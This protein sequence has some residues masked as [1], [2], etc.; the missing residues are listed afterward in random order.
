MQ[1]TLHGSG[2]GSV[3]REVASN[4]RGPRFKSSH[5]QKFINIEHLYTVNCVL[6]RQKEKEK[7]AGNGTFLKKTLHGINLFL[8][9]FLRRFLLVFVFLFLDDG[10]GG[11]R[12]HSEN[13]TLLQNM[14]L[15]GRISLDFVQST[16]Q[17][18][19]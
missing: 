8:R 9:Q 10:G 17:L 15:F 4:S 13:F 2:C 16:L 6:K 5:R 12:F 18:E 3:G 1:Q 14:F 11:I 7:E 19:L